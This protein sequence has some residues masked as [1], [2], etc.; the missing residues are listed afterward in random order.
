MGEVFD[1]LVS[2]GWM[3]RKDAVLFA[4]MIINKNAKRIFGS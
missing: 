1:E 2:S 3:N 4:E